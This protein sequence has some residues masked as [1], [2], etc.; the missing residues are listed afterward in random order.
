MPFSNQ[1]NAEQQ[2]PV[3]EFAGSAQVDTVQGREWQYELLA[4]VLNRPPQL[5]FLVARG[6]HM[7]L[8]LVRRWAQLLL[9]NWLVLFSQQAK[10]AKM[11]QRLWYDKRNCDFRCG[12]PL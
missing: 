5:P 8:V 9:R 4:T 11:L 7:L 10:L 12:T 6:D 2:H 1:L 3:R